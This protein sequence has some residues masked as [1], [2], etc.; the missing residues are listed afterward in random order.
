MAWLTDGK[1]ILKI[2]LFTFTECT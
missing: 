1:Q 2:C